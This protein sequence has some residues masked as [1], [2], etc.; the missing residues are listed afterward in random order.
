MKTFLLLFSSIL[1]IGC[2]KSKTLADIM[3][4]EGAKSELYGLKL[5]I[6]NT[7][8]V[9]SKVLTD[10]NYSENVDSLRSLGFQC[11]YMLNS[12]A[13]YLVKW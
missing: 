9:D 10:I 3:R 7:K 2:N 5:K 12:Y 13:S 11:D 4:E 8:S 1:F 6:K